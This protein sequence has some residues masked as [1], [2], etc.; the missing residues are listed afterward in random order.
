LGPFLF[1]D[2]GTRRAALDREVKKKK[3]TGKSLRK[4]LG[5][6][7]LERKKTV[8]I[9]P[10]RNDSCAPLCSGEEKVR[11]DE[12][13]VAKT[14]VSCG[15]VGR[16]ESHR[17]AKCKRHRVVWA[18]IS[19]FLYGDHSPS[20]WHFSSWAPSLTWEEEKWREN[21]GYYNSTRYKGG[22]VKASTWETQQ[23]TNQYSRE[24]Q[25]GGPD[26]VM[27]EWRANHKV[28]ESTYR[29]ALTFFP[30]PRHKEN[31]ENAPADSRTAINAPLKGGRKRQALILKPARTG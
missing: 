8:W 15:R 28:D 17:G 23:V 16:G 26:L 29:T 11:T 21:R 20:E 12:G 7:S 3:C 2:R 1:G 10:G 30:T 22:N 13:A 25:R 27:G 19:I 4:F 18:P 14:S 9:P 24:H 31:V 6:R 5:V